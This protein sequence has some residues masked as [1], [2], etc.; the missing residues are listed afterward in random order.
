MLITAATASLLA[1]SATAAPQIHPLQF[2]EGRTEGSGVIR[3]MFKKPYRSRSIGKGRIESD[4]SLSLVQRVEDEGRPVRE[5][6][7]KIR[8]VGANR[9]SG[10]MSEAIGPVSI[11]VVGGRYRFRFK[12]K[13]NLSVEQWLAP[14]ANGTAARNRLI[15]RKF[16]VT[17]GTSEGVIRKLS[18]R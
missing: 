12:M 4:G 2:F 10:T 15:V 7:W 16:G 13:G 1:T 11:E 3:I 6:K 8:Q 5:R 17:V 9:F 14:L 18:G